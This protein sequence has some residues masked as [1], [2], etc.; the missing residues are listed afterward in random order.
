MCRGQ[1]TWGTY[2][3]QRE[4]ENIVKF[5]ITTWEASFYNGTASENSTGL[6][7]TVQPADVPRGPCWETMVGQVRVHVCVFV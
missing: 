1:L 5:N 3:L 4:E 2:V 6:P 7:F